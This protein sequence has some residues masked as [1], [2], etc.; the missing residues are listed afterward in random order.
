MKQISCKILLCWFHVKKT[1][2]DNLL[3]KVNPSERNELYQ[4]MSQLMYCCAKSEFNVMYKQI[5]QKY[6]GKK[7][8]CEYI[9]GGWCGI[10][11]V[12]RNLW[13]KFGRLFL[14]GM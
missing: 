2:V 11:C 10:N 6:K 5:I 9:E 7:G 3:P 12:W 14:Y 1:W 13:P 4:R 8:V